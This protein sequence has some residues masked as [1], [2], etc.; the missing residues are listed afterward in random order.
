MDD[1]RLEGL[2]RENRG[3]IF[4]LALRLTGNRQDA[5]DVTQ[6]TMMAAY[7]Y[8]GRFR[9]EA[10]F[11][12]YLYRIGVNFSFSLLKKRKNRAHV[13]LEMARELASGVPD[14]AQALKQGESAERMRRMLEELP[15]RRRAAIHLRLYDDLSFNEIAAALGCR[16]ATARTLF[17][18][19]VRNLR[20]R[21]GV[22]G[23]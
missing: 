10:K 19:G 3:K 17:F 7:R 20:K 2:L 8:R 13:P 14:P 18:F 4:R 1:V 6:E 9:G 5:L 12:T 22:S 21:L 23:G 15:P 16:P 11:S